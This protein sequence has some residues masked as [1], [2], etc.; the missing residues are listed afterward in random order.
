[1]RRYLAASIGCGVVLAFS[2]IGTAIALGHMVAGIVTDP[3]T[4]TITHWRTSVL[5]LAA[6]WVVRVATIWV[7]GRL[8]QHAAAAAITEISGDVLRAVTA[9]PSN[10]MAGR[11]DAA[12][13]LVT[14]GLDGLRPYFVS[15]LPA[16]Y[17]AAI[18]TPAT[19][20]VIAVNDFQSAV[21][22]LVA[23]PLIPVF[24]VLIGLATAE[25]S[26][27]ALAALTTLQTRL[28]DLIAGIPTLRALGRADGA[29]DRIADLTAAHRR[30]TMATL[31]IAFLSALVLELIATLG[32]AL[33]AVSIGLRLVFGEMTLTA[34]LTVLLLAPEVFWPLRRVGSEFHSAQSG[35]T[36]LDQ[37]FALTECP[38][39]APRGRLTLDSPATLIRLEGLSVLGRDGMAP[40]A[41]TACI[42]PGQITAL[43]GDNGAGKSTTLEAIAGLLTPDAGSVSIDGIDVAELDLDHWW[44]QLCWLPQR[45][46]L[47]PGSVLENLTLLGPIDDIE[48]T[49]RATGF[50]SVLESLPN[51]LDT[52]LGRGGIGLSLGERQR[53]ALARVLGSRAP[54]LLLDEPTAHLDELG[55]TAVLHAIRQRAAAG[56]TVVMVGHRSAVLAVADQ[57]VTVES[58]RHVRA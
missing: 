10:V 23:L 29:A 15:Y 47:I 19:V 40:Y 34:G 35:L 43:T 56:A 48:S 5:I 37:A 52:R 55:E 14:T 50:D 28:M 27:A 39:P 41:L 1:M 46:V 21:I 30:S 17:L 22:V 6:L 36:A 7:Q 11:R 25:R 12:A 32:V 4:R 31:R 42:R 49:C 26:A 9:L 54:I 33:V 45:P 3:T 53:L 16:L 58:S 51:G 44:R 13:V 2:T 38:E 24:M 20:V 18:L 8:S 57:V